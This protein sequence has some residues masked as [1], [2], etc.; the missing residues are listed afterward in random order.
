MTF[1]RLPT[2]IKDADG[3]SGN[4]PTMK[5]NCIS[6]CKAMFCWFDNSYSICVPVS[7]M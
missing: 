6:L 5:K 3:L 7:A 1:G 2:T 4:S